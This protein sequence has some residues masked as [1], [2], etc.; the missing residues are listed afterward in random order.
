MILDY[1]HYRDMLSRIK[2]P[3]FAIADGDRF[4]GSNNQSLESFMSYGFGSG[5]NGTLLTEIP[6]SNAMDQG[7]NWD[8]CSNVGLMACSQCFLVKYCSGRCQRQHW[9]KHRLDCEHPY[10]NPRWQPDWVNENRRPHL[11]DV[12]FLAASSSGNVYKNPG[13]ASYDCLR[14]ESNEGVNGL[15]RNLKLCM[16]SAGDLRNLIKTVNSLPNGYTRRLDI[17]FNN[18]NAIILNRMLVILAVLL[19]PGP[20]IEESSE[21]ALHLMYSASIPDT[22][23]AY[24][25]YCVNQIYKGHLESKHMTFEAALKTRG[26]GKL[27]SAQPSVSVRRPVEMFTSTY[28]LQKAANSFKEMLQDPLLIDDRH[29]MLS[30]LKPSHRLTLDRFWKTGVLSPFSLNL[31]A[32]RSPNRLLYSPQGEWLSNTPAVNPLHGW[33]ISAVKQAGL[34]H[35]LDPS[36]DILGCLFFHI[37]SELREFCLRIKEFNINIHLLQ[38]DARLLSKGVSIGVLPA[39]FD[40]SFDRIDAGDLCD[41]TSVAECLADWG[42]LL[43]KANPHASLIIHS[44]KWHAGVPNAVARNNPLAVKILMEKCR[45]SQTLKTRLQ[46]LFRNP[47]APSLARLMASLDAFVDHERAFQEYLDAQE[48]DSAGES[49]GLRRR[50]FHCVHAKRVGVSLCVPEQKLPDLTKEGFYDLF[51]IGGA[52]LT[53]RFAEFARI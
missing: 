48:I 49:L 43:N 42:P 39:F 25:R 23:A 33:D 35:G 1:N 38:Y 2:K 37:K 10:M 22:G 44:K 3:V 52:D 27:Y 20:S 29:K 9:A 5:T 24:V 4:E 26:R 14:I 28:S 34:R 7:A 19:N 36:G 30:M 21:L 11:S 6:C 50:K 31:E 51:T 15:P 17:L 46:T 40:A 41:Q 8:G 13:L 16:C 45:A 12:A 32:F 47:E 18:S 53:L